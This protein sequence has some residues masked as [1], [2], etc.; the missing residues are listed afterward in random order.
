MS[1]IELTE[2]DLPGDD[3]TISSVDAVSDSSFSITPPITASV[4]NGTELNKVKQ[5]KGA[6]KCSEGVVK[7]KRNREGV[8]LT[9]TDA[10]ELRGP[11][12]SAWEIV[13]LGGEVTVEIERV[14][15][16]NRWNKYHRVEETVITLWFANKRCH[17]LTPGAARLLFDHWGTDAKVWCGRS[18][19]IMAKYR[20]PAEHTDPRRW[21]KL[22]DDRGVTHSNWVEKGAL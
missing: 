16:E 10:I 12:M 4:P 13:D 5:S 2:D 8:E 6:V 18:I 21:V 11:D 22:V 3:D 15:K 19:T 1:D 9:Q 17:T 7:G 20:N 14:R